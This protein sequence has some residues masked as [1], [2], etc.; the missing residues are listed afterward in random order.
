MSSGRSVVLRGAN[1]QIKDTDAVV[2][3][4]SWY[5]N[6]AEEVHIPL[7]QCEGGGMVA[8]LL[9]AAHAAKVMP[10]TRRQRTLS[11]GGKR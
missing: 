9:A 3:G 2:V 10:K 8:S 11:V 1:T 5:V 6:N 7:L 4:S